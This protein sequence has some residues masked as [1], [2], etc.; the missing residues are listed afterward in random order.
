MQSNDEDIQ[1]F[2]SP[3]NIDDS[4]DILD[5]RFL[6]ECSSQPTHIFPK[7]TSNTYDGTLAQGTDD[8]EVFL[9]EPLVHGLV[10]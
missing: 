6:I 4:N 9:D 10:E 3:N 2:L 7:K 5:Q 1:F 8:L